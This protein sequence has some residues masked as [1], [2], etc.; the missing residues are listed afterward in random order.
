VL[1]RAFCLDHFDAW[2]FV[3]DA[4]LVDDVVVAAAGAAGTDR[5]FRTW[6]AL[7]VSVACAGAP[8]RSVSPSAA[9][10]LSARPP[11]DGL[12]VLAFFSG[13]WDFAVL[14]HVLRMTPDLV[15]VA[16]RAARTARGTR[17]TMGCCAHG[18]AIPYE[19]V[20][21]SLARGRF[22]LRAPFC[23]DAAAERTGTER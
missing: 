4:A 1:A 8:A 14:R 3:A 17:V 12:I 19:G 21:E 10:A 16:Y 6:L 18:T 13:A 7:V 9:V 15:G 20:K 2:A 23:A 22:R 5:R 11:A